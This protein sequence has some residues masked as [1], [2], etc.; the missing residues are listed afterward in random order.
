MLLFIDVPSTIITAFRNPSSSFK[1]YEWMVS[2]NVGAVSLLICVSKLR[3][4]ILLTVSLQWKLNQPFL[5]RLHEELL[6]LL[7]PL[8]PSQVRQEE[9]FRPGWKP[10]WCFFSF[11]RSLS[12]LT[13]F[14]TTPSNC[15]EDQLVLSQ[16]RRF[17]SFISLCSACGIQLE[18]Y[19]KITLKIC[20]I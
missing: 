8:Q 5:N 14:P 17:S 16:N 7:L 18:I 12:G 4:E 13:S 20:V 9:T 15:E 11:S 3:V 6:L 1:A 19:T 2:V 10:P